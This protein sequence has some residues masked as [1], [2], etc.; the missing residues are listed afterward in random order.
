MPQYKEI[1]EVTIGTEVI[2]MQLYGARECLKYIEQYSRRYDIMVEDV[3]TI[4]IADV[5][6]PIEALITKLNPDDLGHIERM[7]EIYR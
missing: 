2:L 1:S 6:A 5:L 7:K 4:H 3:A